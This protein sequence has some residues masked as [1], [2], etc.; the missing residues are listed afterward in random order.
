M[1]QFGSALDW[2][3]R[4]RRFES[5]SPDHRSSKGHE[6]HGLFISGKNSSVIL[7]DACRANE[8]PRLCSAALTPLKL[9]PEGKVTGNLQSFAIN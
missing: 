1:A 5:C 7:I 3:S 2:G 6:F 9:L 8:A 4:G